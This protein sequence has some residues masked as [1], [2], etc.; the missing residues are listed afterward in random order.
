MPSGA[1]RGARQVACTRGSRSGERARSQAARLTSVAFVL[2]ANVCP[3]LRPPFGGHGTDTTDRF[4]AASSAPR[5]SVQGRR[6][7]YE[8]PVSVPQTCRSKWACQV[9][10]IREDLVPAVSGYPRPAACGAASCS[11]CE[12]LAGAPVHRGADGSMT[13]ARARSSSLGDWRNSATIL[14]TGTAELIGMDESRWSPS[15]SD[16]AESAP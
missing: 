8:N 1:R 10:A 6:R 4:G 14:L 3:S 12:S 16:D 7:V 9:A 13:T 15:L 5:M 2:P 11:V